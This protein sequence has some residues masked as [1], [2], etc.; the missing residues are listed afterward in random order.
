MKRKKQLGA[1]VA[2]LGDPLLDQ[3]NDERAPDAAHGAELFGR[4]FRDVREVSLARG[5]RKPFFPGGLL[6]AR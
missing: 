6:G 4:E 3:P 1:G 2:S 5:R